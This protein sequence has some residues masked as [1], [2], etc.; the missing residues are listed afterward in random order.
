MHS[1]WSLFPN[2]LCLVLLFHTVDE[3]FEF[4]PYVTPNVSCPCQWAMDLIWRR[5]SE[6][7]S[8]RSILDVRLTPWRRVF[9]PKGTTAISDGVSNRAE[10]DT[11]SAMHFSASC[12]DVL[13]S[14]SP[15]KP[16]EKIRRNM[17]VVQ[18]HKAFLDCRTLDKRDVTA[19]ALQATA[20][21]LFGYERAALDAGS[22]AGG[23]F[24]THR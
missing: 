22:L 15:L 12:L 9:P 1:R 24:W 5:C 21:G 11:T 20:F 7:T 14:G 2:D 17:S 4:V 10:T 19:V 8:D 6:P 3:V 13:F 18:S 23:V 16:L